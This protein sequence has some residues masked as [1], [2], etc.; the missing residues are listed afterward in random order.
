MIMTLNYSELGRDAMN[1]SMDE[2][3]EQITAFNKATEL[4]K[5][6]KSFRNECGE[7]S[8]KQKRAQTNGK[9]NATKSASNSEPDKKATAPAP[10]PKHEPTKQPQK[11]ASVDEFVSSSNAR[12]AQPS[13][14]PVA[15]RPASQSPLSFG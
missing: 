2:L 6:A 9:K 14:T 1:I 3:E 13:H 12:P 5:K 15:N 7:Y 10:Q 4:L 8:S 11:S